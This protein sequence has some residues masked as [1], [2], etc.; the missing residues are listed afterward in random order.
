[1]HPPP[2]VPLPPAPTPRV[3]DELFSIERAPPPHAITAFEVAKTAGDVVAS[4]SA[5]GDVCIHARVLMR[6]VFCCQNRRRANSPRPSGAAAHVLHH[7]HS[8]QIGPVLMRAWMEAAYGCS[9]LCLR[10]IYCRQ[11][12]PVR[13]FTFLRRDGWRATP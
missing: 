5:W 11:C 9:S 1:M 12:L 13:V 10:G 4:A 6:D 8:R 2:L 3:D 7:V